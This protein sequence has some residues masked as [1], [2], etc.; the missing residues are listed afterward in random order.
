MSFFEYYAIILKFIVTNFKDR[1]TSFV[2]TMFS[3]GLSVISKDI[4]ADLSMCFVCWKRYSTRIIVV[5]ILK[6]PAQQTNA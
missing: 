3:L 5:L 4:F 6:Y 2:T 1:F